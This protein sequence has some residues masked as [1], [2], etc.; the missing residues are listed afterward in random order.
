MPPNRDDIIQRREGANR[1]DKNEYRRPNEE[2]PDGAVFGASRAVR[3][4]SVLYI[5]FIATVCTCMIVFVPDIASNPVIPLLAF[6]LIAGFELYRL[7]WTY[8]KNVVLRADEIVFRRGSREIARYP[9]AGHTF[10]SA[11]NDG[12]SIDGLG[13]RAGYVLFIQAEGGARKKYFLPIS[14]KDLS[15]LLDTL[16]ACTIGAAPHEGSQDA[17][18]ATFSGTKTFVLHKGRLKKYMIGGSAL[19]VVALCLTRLFWHRAVGENWGLLV[20]PSAAAVGAIVLLGWWRFYSRKM[21]DRVILREGFI[22]L[23]NRTIATNEIQSVR[24]A[25]AL[26]TKGSGGRKIEIATAA[27]G[28]EIWFLGMY[29]DTKPDKSILHVDDYREIA[30]FLRAALE[31]RPDAFRTEAQ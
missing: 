21:P 28:R 11:V 7:L 26:Q 17:P 25:S 2:V 9:Y 24:A 14:R 13:G 5:L 8:R 15:R 19:A 23:G 31:D 3:L 10:T 29:G 18:R 12:V 4:L 16:E 22:S 30:T 6:T 27:R 1:L 20:L